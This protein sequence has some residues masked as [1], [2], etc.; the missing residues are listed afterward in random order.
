MTRALVTG[1]TGFLGRHAARRLVQ[2]GWEVSGMG[3]SSTAGKLLE[4]EGVR[5]VQTD[6]RDA[7]GVAEA[8]A[9]QDY[10]FHC[11]ALSAPWGL[12]MSSMAAM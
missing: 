3:R 5:F 2:L 1:A 11:G 12:T 9:G 10:V 6:L 4:Q 7:V 8:C